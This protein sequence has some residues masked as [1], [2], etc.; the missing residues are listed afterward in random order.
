MV[1]ECTIPYQINQI[2]DYT[3]AIAPVEI[4]NRRISAPLV[5]HWR[6]F[7]KRTTEACCVCSTP[8]RIQQVAHVE[9]HYRTL[10]V[11]KLR[12]SHIMGDCIIVEDDDAG[13]SKEFF[14]VPSHYSDD[15]ESVL[16]PRGIILDRTA[17]IAKDIHEKID[18][19]K[20]L[21]AL[22]VLK[23][24]YIFFNDL[25]EQL[26]ALSANANKSCRMSIDFIRLK[27]YTDSTSTGT[28]KVIGGDDLS[29]IKGKNVLVVEDIVDSGRT[30]QKLL[31]ILDEN[32]PNAVRVV[33]LLVKRTS[34]STGYRPDHIGFEV[35][36]KFVVG[37]G[38]DYNEYFR[39][40]GHICIM[41]PDSVKKYS[42]SNS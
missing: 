30:M 36:D 40:L 14:S 11:R 24:S 9:K 3:L 6:S 5:H 32:E 31:K 41:S 34:R 12:W 2:L 28:I 16:L 18:L 10:L 20:P 29:E 33:S 35:P 4:G 21:V 37:Y 22:C 15:L 25:L 7:T 27:S 1:F 13:Y 19:S 17:K 38:L 39:D 23:G 8:L 26:R 42:I